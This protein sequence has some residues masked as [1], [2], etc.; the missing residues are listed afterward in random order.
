M[1]SSPLYA[2]RDSLARDD[3]ASAH[4]APLK[5]GQD[6]R[7]PGLV[8]QPLPHQQNLLRWRYPHFVNHRPWSLYQEARGWM[9]W[10]LVKWKHRWSDNSL[11]KACPAQGAYLLQSR[12]R[13]PKTFQIREHSDLSGV[14]EMVAQV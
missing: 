10:G 7:P 11:L 14:E 6:L 12:C 5:V 1:P 9:R 13:S 8:C 2:K 4:E 3:M